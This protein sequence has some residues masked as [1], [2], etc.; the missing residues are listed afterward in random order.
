MIE[1]RGSQTNTIRLVNK[2]F[3]KF[4]T[5][6]TYKVTMCQ[7]YN[8]D[9]VCIYEACISD[10]KRNRLKKWLFGQDIVMASFLGYNNNITIAIRDDVLRNTAFAAALVRTIVSFFEGKLKLEKG[11]KLPRLRLPEARVTP[12]SSNILTSVGGVII[13]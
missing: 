6:F 10:E 3:N 7:Q 12:V 11:F 13:F 5:K 1:Y 2:E 9:Q 4:K 8:S